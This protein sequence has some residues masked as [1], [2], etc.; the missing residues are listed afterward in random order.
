[1]N[2]KHFPVPSRESKSN[3][4]DTLTT[5][6][7][8]KHAHHNSPIV[9]NLDHDKPK[10]SF[11]KIKKHNRYNSDRIN[12]SKPTGKTS[13][14]KHI[15]RGKIAI[16]Y[17]SRVKSPERASKPK[18]KQTY[19]IN[20]Y[21]KKEALK[22]THTF[23]VA[24][25]FKSLK[26]VQ[27]HRSNNSTPPSN[28]GLQ[29]QNTSDCVL[30]KNEKNSL[31]SEKCFMEIKPPKIPL[32]PKNKNDFIEPSQI[33]TKGASLSNT[34]SKVNKYNTQ[35]LENVGWKKEQIDSKLIKSAFE[36]NNNHHEVNKAKAPSSPPKDM[37]IVHRHSVNPNDT[38]A[39]VPFTEP[40]KQLQFFATSEANDLFSLEDQ[41]IN[42]DALNQ[43]NYSNNNILYFRNLSTLGNPSRYGN[44]KEIEK[45][46]VLES[47]DNSPFSEN[48]FDSNYGSATAFTEFSSLNLGE[49]GLDFSLPFNQ[50]LENEMS[51]SDAY[52][53]SFEDTNN[54]IDN[55]CDKQINKVTSLNQLLKNK[56][57]AEFVLSVTMENLAAAGKLDE[58][59][60]KNQI[61]RQTETTISKEK[62]LPVATDD[63][64]LNVNNEVKTKSRVV[65]FSTKSESQNLWA[66]DYLNSY[67][68]KFDDYCG[69]LGS[70]NKV[71]SKGPLLSNKNITNSG[72]TTNT[73]SIKPGI[74]T[75]SEGSVLVPNTKIVEVRQQCSK[76]ICSISR[77]IDTERHNV[78]EVN[79]HS[80]VELVTMNS[81]KLNDQ[82]PNKSDG[83]NLISN[84]QMVAFKDRI[85][86]G[87]TKKPLPMEEENRLDRPTRTQKQVIRNYPQILA[88]LIFKYCTDRFK[89]GKVFKKKLYNTVYSRKMRAFI[90]ERKHNHQSA[91]SEFVGH[92]SIKK[93]PKTPKLN[94]LKIRKDV[95]IIKFFNH[96]H[97][98]TLLN[99][100]DFS[101]TLIT[102]LSK[103]SNDSKVLKK[104]MTDLEIVAAGHCCSENETCIIRQPIDVDKSAFF[105]KVD[106]PVEIQC[107]KVRNVSTTAGND[108][109]AKQNHPMQSAKAAGK[110]GKD[111]K[112]DKD[113]GGN[114]VHSGSWEY[115]QL[116]NKKKR[117]REKGVTELKK[118]D[119]T[120]QV[121]VSGKRRG[122]FTMTVR[123]NNNAGKGENLVSYSEQTRFNPIYGVGDHT[124]ISM[125]S[126]SVP[127]ATFSSETDFRSSP[128]R[129]KSSPLREKNQKLVIH[130]GTMN[131]SQNSKT[132]QK[133]DNQN[134]TIN[135][136]QVSM[137]QP[138]KRLNEIVDQEKIWRRQERPTD[139][140]ST[141]NLRDWIKN[142]KS[143]SFSDIARS[144]ILDEVIIRF[145]PG[146]SDYSHHLSSLDIELDSEKRYSSSTNQKGK[147]FQIS[148]PNKTR[149]AKVP[150]EIE[151]QKGS[152]ALASST[153]DSCFDETDNFL[154]IFNAKTFEVWSKTMQ[155]SA[156]WK[157]ETHEEV[158][159]S[160]WK[161][162][163]GPLSPSRNASQSASFHQG[164]NASDYEKP[165]SSLDDDIFGNVF[166]ESIN[167]TTSFLENFAKRGFEDIDERSWQN[168]PINDKSS[169]LYDMC[170]D[171][172]EVQ[173][174]REPKSES[175]TSSFT[176]SS[177]YDKKVDN[178]DDQGNDYI[179][180][181]DFD[182]YG[183]MSEQKLPSSA[184]VLIDTSGRLGQV[185]T[186]IHHDVTSE[187]GNDN[188]TMSRKIDKDS[189]EKKVCSK[190]DYRKKQ[191]HV[192]PKK[193]VGFTSMININS[194]NKAKWWKRG[195]TKE[196][197]EV[198]KINEKKIDTKIEVNLRNSSRQKSFDTRSPFKDAFSNVRDKLKF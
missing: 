33:V 106:G 113:N 126:N 176:S 117:I 38:D 95:R 165:M 109:I 172:K 58:F 97:I 177:R 25:K 123:Q 80:E 194:T 170:K 57:E 182:G 54:I 86:F 16:D 74:I 62:N 68:R 39:H 192:I 185:S 19:N 128:T 154:A 56:E 190:N 22:A 51:L 137:Y 174:L 47:K 42:P 181:F 151:S 91:I 18:Q 105:S 35:R 70:A 15:D 108:S 44:F 139:S 63:K 1:M 50:S 156:P 171:W 118:D 88:P 186:C 167:S 129:A 14:E 104:Q 120:T 43:D 59:E 61:N 65:S 148:S 130:T 4:V 178:S 110:I 26:S 119:S 100:E 9:S 83:Y 188:E 17:D 150:I 179:S 69:G 112:E 195:G 193:E 175:R 134:F 197:Q 140:L 10:G 66:S 131:K 13:T 198:I 116:Q 132:R 7:K 32:F 75:G 158:C 155:K 27:N 142:G 138:S 11:K 160:G 180:D 133:S 161:F 159:T 84:N 127:N 3:I 173:P 82:I 76:N 36:N 187:G 49:F 34:K 46:F 85:L 93:P 103:T 122:W 98:E 96:W 169:I 8:Q 90:Q 5:D 29:H 72:L 162:E 92:L 114:T 64:C 121:Q 191:L 147:E 141:G 196:K 31:V 153:L 52:F 94:V 124:L 189:K 101:K 163:E 28:C 60:Y 77:D 107:A 53:Y 152:S 73:K 125:T 24:E 20:S 23:Q 143:G 149:G 48:I 41:Y 111:I 12:Y 115:R 55:C 144:K 67:N 45:Y 79:Q 21:K 184:N 166:D 164:S 168:T 2:S 102:R 78:L 136:K 30:A 89:T 87:L 146:S 157:M 81:V 37:K 183:S 71:H 135:T 99:D 6:K 145:D 40:D